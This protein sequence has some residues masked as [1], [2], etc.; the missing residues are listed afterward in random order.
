MTAL[1]EDDVRRIVREEI[2]NALGMLS[3][4][5]SHLDGYGTDTIEM[6]AL[7]AVSKAAEGAAVRMTCPHEVYESWGGL[8]VQAPS[9]CRRCGEPEPEPVNPFEEENSRG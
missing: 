1:N 9:T 4:E 2:A 5:A 6:Y 8:Y 7:S 3:R